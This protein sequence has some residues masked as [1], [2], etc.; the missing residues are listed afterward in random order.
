MKNPYIQNVSKSLSKI[1]VCLCTLIFIFTQ[2]SN[3]QSLP[4]IQRFDTLSVCDNNFPVYYA[5]ST[6]Y[7]A[8][9]YQIIYHIFV[10]DEN[11]E[12]EPIA[13]DSVIYLTIITLESYLAFDSLFVC[14]NAFPVIA[15][16]NTYFSA[17]E[18]ILHFNSVDLCDSIIWFYI[19][20][21]PVFEL[22]DTI[23]VCADG[24]N[25]YPIENRGL[26]IVA[27]GNYTIPFFSENGCDSIIKLRVNE[28]PYYISTDESTI[29][30]KELPFTYGDSTFYESGIYSIYFNSK[31]NCDSVIVFTLNI[32][33]DYYIYDTVSV[34]AENLPHLY[35]DVYYSTPGDYVLTHTSEFGC[36][37]IIYFAFRIHQQTTPI[38]AGSHDLCVSTTSTISISN[39]INYVGYHWSNGLASSSITVSTAGDFRVIT[40]DNHGCHD[41]SS[42]FNVVNDLPVSITAADTVICAGKTTTFTAHGGA[43]YHWSTGSNNA[44]ITVSE[45]RSYYVTI[46]NNPNCVNYDTISLRLYP[47][48]DLTITPIQNICINANSGATLPTHTLLTVA[49]SSLLT[50]FIWSTGGNTSSIDV[51]PIIRTI[52][53]VTATNQYACTATAQTMVIPLPEITLDGNL[54]LCKGE[55]TTLTATGGIQYDW[56]GTTESTYNIAFYSPLNNTNC[57][58]KVTTSEGCFNNKTF[59]I[60]VNP[61]PTT[62]ILG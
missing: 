58:V 8:G 53:H 61:L 52:Y 54:T 17:G 3:A 16:G 22:F 39:N 27:P 23:S 55:Q 12:A 38:L 7:T 18:D 19:I 35:R 34:C 28:R 11:E 15:H 24:N 2:K 30:S 5:D 9:H 47:L 33:P 62:G 37:S 40:T 29:C 59:Q 42:Y 41:T 44:T 48:P 31:V 57:A 36:D 10:P 14:A 50:S 60:I 26:T 13:V 25:S 49:D 43:L 32:N 56:T 21:N 6:Y 45:Q 4:E 46:S 51:N 20:E 1:V